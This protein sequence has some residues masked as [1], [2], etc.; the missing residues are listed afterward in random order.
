MPSWLM[1]LLKLAIQI[2]SPYLL[3]LVK[4]WAAKLPAEV[5]QIINDLIGS[6]KDPAV[7][8]SYAKKIAKK[9][10]KDHCSGVAC[11]PDTLKV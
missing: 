10:L 1:V 9:R 2:G 7:P 3:E 8:N 4:K 6:I 5:I 11:A